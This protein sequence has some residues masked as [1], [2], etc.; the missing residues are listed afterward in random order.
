MLSED[1]LEEL[2]AVQVSA[3][4]E[5]GEIWK[6]ARTA[7]RKG[8]FAETWSPVKNETGQAIQFPCR[9]GK[10]G[11]PAELALAAKQGVITP[12]TLTLPVGSPAGEKDQVRVNERKFRVIGGLHGSWDTA[13]RLICEEM[14]E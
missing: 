14:P 13:L 4:P 10:T 7:D 2:R 9:I 6:V 12:Y 5:V 1:E 8:G 11:K 3:M